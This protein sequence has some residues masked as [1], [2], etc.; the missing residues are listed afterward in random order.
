MYTIEK[1]IP[2]VN[3]KY[4]FAEMVPGDSVHI[5][6]NARRISTVRMAIRTYIK[7][8]NS[9]YKFATRKT[10]TGLRIWCVQP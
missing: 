5:E 10:E 4:P 6:G 7:K 8:A 1:N 2:L 3:T 9:P